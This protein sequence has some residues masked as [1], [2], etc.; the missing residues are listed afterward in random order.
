L[1][2]TGLDGRKI[3]KWI[4]MKQNDGNDGSRD[5]WLVNMVMEFGFNMNQ[6][7]TISFPRTAAHI[8]ITA[9]SYCNLAPA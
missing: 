2:D 7:I 9:F 3:L 4:S 6:G 8:L 5:Q 1:G